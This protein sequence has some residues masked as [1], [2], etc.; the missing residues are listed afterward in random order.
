MGTKRLRRFLR[1]GG[2]NPRSP[3]LSNKGCEGNEGVGAYRRRHTQDQHWPVQ[4][5]FRPKKRQTHLCCCDLCHMNSAEEGDNSRET[6]L[7]KGGNRGWGKG[8][9]KIRWPICSKDLNAGLYNPKWIQRNK[10]S[11]PGMK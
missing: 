3:L 11:Q 8:G 9:F 5:K 4:A 1:E 6:Q 10:G 2:L 7:E